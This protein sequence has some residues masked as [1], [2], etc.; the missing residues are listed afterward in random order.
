M[1]SARVRAGSAEER[2]ARQTMARREKRMDQLAA[3]EERL[4]AEVV[5]HATDHA[6]LTEL[7]RSLGELASERAAL[8]EEW[9]EA[10]EAVE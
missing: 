9:L 5:A 4:N 2:P 7:S 1:S 10:A 6:R 8:E 3:E